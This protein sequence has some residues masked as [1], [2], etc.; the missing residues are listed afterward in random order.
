M[1]GGYADSYGAISPLPAHDGT[2]CLKWDE[3]LWSHAEHFRVR[4]LRALQL[5]N[6]IGQ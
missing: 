5:H 2:E 3:S 6:L 1:E 4:T